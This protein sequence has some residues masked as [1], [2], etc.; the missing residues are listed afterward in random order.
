MDDEF[1][2]AE[3]EELDPYSASMA[4]VPDVTPP[5]SILTVDV[6]LDGN[7]PA[8]PVDTPIPFTMRSCK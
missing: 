1:S 6:F 5:G 3:G 7:T 8:T 2:A 4:S